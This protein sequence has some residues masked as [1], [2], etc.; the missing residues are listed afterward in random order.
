M[1]IKSAS[2]NSRRRRIS[3]GSPDALA[4]SGLT[5][6][7]FDLDGT[8]IDNTAYHIDAWLTLLSKHNRFM[9]AT[10][11]NQYLGQSTDAIL[12]QV[13][14]SASVR[15]LESFELEKDKIYREKY[16]GNVVPTPGFL[17]YFEALRKRHFK[18]ALA[19]TS[20]KTNREFV[21]EHLGIFEA[22]D[23]ILGHEHVKRHKPDPEVFIKVAEHLDVAVE[24]CVVFEDTPIGVT[25]AKS[26]GM[27]VIAVAITTQP[28]MLHNADLVVDDFRA[29]LSP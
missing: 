7:I 2:N 18:L 16:E 4:H 15:E 10:E 14:T 12:R 25:A 20:T 8:V 28:E 1:Q 9:T 26:A 11:F 21:L 17:Q 29:L 24:T 13:F 23:L 3:T 22:F 19:T 5:V 6:A 27:S